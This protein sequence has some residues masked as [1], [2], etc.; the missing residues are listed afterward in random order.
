MMN[1]EPTRTANSLQQFPLPD[2]LN[3]QG[4]AITELVKTAS[5]LATRLS[6]VREESPVI[7]ASECDCAPTPNQAHRI[8]QEN[9]QRICGVTNHLRQILNELTF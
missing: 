3:V 4:D 6:Y 5:D 1:K 8:I 2:S 7:S 9:T